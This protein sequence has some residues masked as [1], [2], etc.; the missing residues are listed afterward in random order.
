MGESAMPILFA[1][2]NSLIVTDKS[3]DIIDTKLN[4]NIKIVYNCS[5]CNLLCINFSK[6]YSMYFTTR[7]CNTATTKAI[8]SCNS[9]EIMEVY[10]LKFLGLEIDNALSWDIR[11]DT[12]VNKLT[13]VSFMIRS[14]KTIYVPC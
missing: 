14:V 8:I 11:I 3:L 9:N 2:D 10:H 13:R 5:K 7:N 6:T 12:V 4:V 1:D